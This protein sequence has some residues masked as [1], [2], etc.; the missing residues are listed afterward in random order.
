LDTVLDY[1]THFSSPSALAS[2]GGSGLDLLLWI[3]FGII[4]AGAVYWLLRARGR[5]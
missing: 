3:A 2:S 4:V 1:N 5:K